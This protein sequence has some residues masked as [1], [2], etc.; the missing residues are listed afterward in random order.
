MLARAGKLSVAG[1]PKVRNPLAYRYCRRYCRSLGYS[2]GGRCVEG[3]GG[4]TDSQIAACVRHQHNLLTA[5]TDE[6]HIDVSRES[7]R[8]AIDLHDHF[9]NSAGHATDVDARRIGCGGGVILNGDS[10]RGREGLRSW[11]PLPA[12]TVQPKL[13]LAV[14]PTKPSLTVTVT[15]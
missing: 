9:A 13:A 8:Q 4:V 3:H 1:L 6:Q 5:R 10:G 14:P 7:M 11:T 15:V 2:S 12:A